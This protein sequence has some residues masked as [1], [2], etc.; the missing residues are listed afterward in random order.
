MASSSRQECTAG[1]WSSQGPR[2]TIPEARES[3]Y[4]LVQK[5]QIP[6]ARYRQDIGVRLFEHDLERLITLGLISD[7]R[8]PVRGTR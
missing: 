5:I 3:T 8:P 7:C 4:A 1:Q 2:K 6:N